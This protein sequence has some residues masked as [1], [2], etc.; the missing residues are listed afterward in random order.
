MALLPSPGVLLLNV[1]LNISACLLCAHELNQSQVVTTED[2]FSSSV[3]L[4]IRL[5]L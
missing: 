4:W 3:R 5:H 1:H 2:F